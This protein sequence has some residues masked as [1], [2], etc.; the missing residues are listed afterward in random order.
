MARAAPRCAAH[1][2]ER[3]QRLSRAGE[4]YSVA[5]SRAER[6]AAVSGTSESTS[7]T[8]A[9]HRNGSSIRP[10]TTRPDRRRA[11]P[12]RPTRSSRDHHLAPRCA[13]TSPKSG[14]NPCGDWHFYGGDKRPAFTK[15]HQLTS[16][17]QAD[18]QNRCSREG[19]TVGQSPASVLDALAC[20][21]DTAA[22]LAVT[23]PRADRA[24][25]LA[26]LEPQR[27]THAGRVDAL[28]AIER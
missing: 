4:Q 17:T 11:T 1:R 5:T 2:Y 12:E 6:Q 23:A 25:P 20:P 18:M 28:V 27:L 15:R 19:K 10:R 24:G 16:C 3:T 13:P 26:A 8:V 9:A 21:D 7:G 22:Y 14:Q